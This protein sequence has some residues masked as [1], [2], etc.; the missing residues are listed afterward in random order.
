MITHTSHP[1]VALQEQRAQRIERLRKTMALKR[2]TGQVTGR[3]PLGYILSQVNGV[4]V[5]VEDPDTMKLL[6]EAK[7]MQV[8]GVSIRV[9]RRL[10]ERPM[11]RPTTKRCFAPVLDLFPCRPGT[12]VSDLRSQSSTLS[13]G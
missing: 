1:S 2:A 10:R 4:S 8:R 6:A 5:A 13:R 3:L 9:I 12:S 7:E 11:K